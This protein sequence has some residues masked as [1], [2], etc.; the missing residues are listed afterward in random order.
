MLK[1]ARFPGNGNSPHH[2]VP[3]R[4]RR[5]R[6]S[7]TNSEVAWNIRSRSGRLK[8]RESSEAIATDATRHAKVIG[9]LAGKKVTAKKFRRWHKHPMRSARQLSPSARATRSERVHDGL[10]TVC[11]VLPISAGGGPGWLGWP[12]PS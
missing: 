5:I 4:S 6:P 2:Q 1:N 10:M 9:K 3:G 8:G 7:P 11:P 12:P